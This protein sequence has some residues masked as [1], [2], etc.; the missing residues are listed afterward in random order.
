MIFHFWK[1]CYLYA[2]S[3]DSSMTIYKIRQSLRNHTLKVKRFSYYKFIF[4]RFYTV[5]NSKCNDLKK[6]PGNRIFEF[7]RMK[8]PSFEKNDFTLRIQNILPVSNFPRTWNLLKKIL[9]IVSLNLV[10][11][12]L[13]FGGLFQA[14]SAMKFW[15]LS[16]TK[17]SKMKMNKYS[18]FSI[19]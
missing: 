4:Y 16:A 8:K 12:P 17:A 9:L 5:W 14:Q 2:R 19:A 10:S 7:D 15:N 13:H 6:H 11:W 1:F 18:S 3:F